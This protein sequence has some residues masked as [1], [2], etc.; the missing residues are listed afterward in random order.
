MFIVFNEGERKFSLAFQSIIQS[1]CH[2]CTKCIVQF[3][4]K[5]KC[6]CIFVDLLL[7]QTSF[8]FIHLPQ[9]Q[10]I[11]CPLKGKGEVITAL[12]AIR[13]K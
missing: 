9:T 3:K 7:L 6:F 12:Q 10:D 1:Y 4:E 5:E 8:L 2:Y 11:F 13:T